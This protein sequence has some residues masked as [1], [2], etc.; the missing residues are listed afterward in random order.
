MPLFLRKIELTGD[1]PSE[2]YLHALPVIQHIRAAGGLTFTQPVTMLVGENGMGKSTLIEA[3]AIG[4]GFNPEG[5]TR[6]F[7]F[8]T[9]QAHSNL[10][11]YLSFTRGAHYPRD[12]FFLRAESFFNVSSYLEEIND[13]GLAFQAYGGRELHTLSHGE[14]FMALV[15]N[16]FT[17]HGLYILDEPEAALSPMRQMEMLIHF[18]RLA[19]QGAQFI[20]STHAPILMTF[21]GADIIQLNP[22]GFEHVPYQETEHFIIMKRFLNAPDKMLSL[23]LKND[24]R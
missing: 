14:A 1:I 15:E 8:S 20:I 18:Q 7:R 12:G 6:N 13:D 21:P 2:N 24:D 10:H 19:G 4:M 3:I 9:C 23:L 11:E 22:S 16:R 5:G 17:G